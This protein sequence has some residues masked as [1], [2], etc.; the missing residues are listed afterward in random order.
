MSVLAIFI[1]FVSA[2]AI[3]LIHWQLQTEKEYTREEVINK[4]AELR[5]E[6]AWVD[7]ERNTHELNT[8]E[9]YAMKKRIAD[10]VAELER[11]VMG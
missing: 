2:I 4:I 10:E 3:V 9:Y 1:V 7:S 8:I 6:I 5:R 11:K